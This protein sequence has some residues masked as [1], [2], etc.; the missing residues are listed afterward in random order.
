MEGE[1][2]CIE[3]ATEAWNMD[4]SSD[5]L[6]VSGSHI[7]DVEETTGRKR[8]R[9]SFQGCLNRAEVGGHVWVKRVGCCIAPICKVC[10]RPNNHMRR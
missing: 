3:E 1:V 7:K 4:G 2:L 10:N 8:G 5:A 9:C 6:P